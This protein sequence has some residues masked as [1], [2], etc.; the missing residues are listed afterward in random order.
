MKF[1]LYF[2]IFVSITI[3]STGLPDDII[4]DPDLIIDSPDVPVVPEEPKP[5]TAP[6]PNL[7]KPGQMIDQGL[8][9]AQ[10][11]IVDYGHLMFLNDNYSS[12]LFV[13]ANVSYIGNATSLYYA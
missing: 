12:S 8:A 10:Q 1:Y 9:I 7:V 6:I 2:L 11:E 13:S 4:L 5:I 3:I